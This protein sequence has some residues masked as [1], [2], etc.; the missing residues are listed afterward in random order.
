MS[1]AYIIRLIR[2][3]SKVAVALVAA[4]LTSQLLVR[5]VFLGYTPRVRADLAD[6]LVERSIA[7]INLD[8]YPLFNRQREIQRLPADI[9]SL[10]KQFAEMPARALVPGVY[11]KEVDGASY[12]EIHFEQVDWVEI[13]YRRKNGERETIKIPRG[14]APPPEGLF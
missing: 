9:A 8:R 2:I 14:T 10:T 13:E 12:T 3:Y 4:V 6:R 1:N 7:L 11:A 5:E